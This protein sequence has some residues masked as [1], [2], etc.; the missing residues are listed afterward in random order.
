MPSLVASLLG[1]RAQYDKIF[2]VITIALAGSESEAQIHENIL[3]IFGFNDKAR[4]GPLRNTCS[5]A[6]E[7][8]VNSAI[9][10]LSVVISQV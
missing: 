4:L 8:D 7:V 2:K 5:I 9:V 10:G 1:V 3:L 6:A